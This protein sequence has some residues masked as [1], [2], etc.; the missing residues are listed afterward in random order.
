MRAFVCVYACVLFDNNINNTLMD[1]MHTVNVKNKGTS[2]LTIN[3]F[4]L[5]KEN[6]SEP[7]VWQ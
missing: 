2:P 5:I 4:S 6:F 3:T 1:C 7:N